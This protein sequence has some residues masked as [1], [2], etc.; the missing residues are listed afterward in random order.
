[1]FTHYRKTLEN[2]HSALAAG[3][4]S[5]GVYHGG[6]STEQ[7]DAVVRDF[8]AELPVLLS[9]EAGGEG[10]NLQ[11]CR[12]LVNYD[13]P[14]NPMRIEQRVGRI[15]RI[16]QKRPVAIYNLAAERTL[17]DYLLKILDEKINMFELVIGEMDMILGQIEEERD[18][19]DLL[20]DLWMKSRSE[21]ELESG[22]ADLGEKLL[23]AKENYLETKETDEKIFAQ[24]FEAV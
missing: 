19:E 16:G 23:K 14:Y 24:D 3:G 12:I 21:K 2:L 13:L 4:I 8:S 6:L 1:M 10:R 11:F 18:F 5:A 7:K 20:L 15:H 9:T 17:E 22:M